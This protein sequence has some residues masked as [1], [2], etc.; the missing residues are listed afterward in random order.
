MLYIQKHCSYEVPPSVPYI[1]KS[2]SSSIPSTQN[3]VMSPGKRITMR[4]GRIDQLKKWH[5]LLEEGVISQED[6]DK[7]QQKILKD[8]M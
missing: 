4:M 8:I 1:N 3:G 2:N 7:V 5:T 6:Y